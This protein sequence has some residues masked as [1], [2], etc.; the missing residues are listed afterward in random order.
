VRLHHAKG[1]LDPQA[2][3]ASRALGNVAAQSSEATRHGAPCY[4]GALVDTLARLEGCLL[5]NL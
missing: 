5:Q 3:G 4:L 2:E 1:L